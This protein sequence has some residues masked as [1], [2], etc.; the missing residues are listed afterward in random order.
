MIL[1]TRGVTGIQ[2]VTGIRG[3][4]GLW[5]MTGVANMTS[6]QDMATYI[7]FNAISGNSSSAIDSDIQATDALRAKVDEL[8]RLF[9][10]KVVVPCPYCGQWGAAMCACKKCG[11]AIGMGEIP[12]ISSKK[13]ETNAQFLLRANEKVKDVKPGRAYC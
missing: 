3:V 11:G 2:G 6:A 1:G 8:E 13:E 5:G 12:E 9:F 4:T 10:R 7:A